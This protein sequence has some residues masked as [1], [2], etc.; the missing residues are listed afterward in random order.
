MADWY[1]EMGDLGAAYD[2]VSNGPI[3]IYRT[4]E[5]FLSLG[6]F[7]QGSITLKDYGGEAGITSKLSKLFEDAGARKKAGVE[8]IMKSFPKSKYVL[9]FSS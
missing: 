8:R 3:E 9:L 1:R 7:P 4:I 6:D 5:E 2:Y